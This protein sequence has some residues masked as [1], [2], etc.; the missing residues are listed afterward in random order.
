MNDDD[1]PA[2]ELAVTLAD[3][4]KELRKEKNLLAAEERKLEVAQEEVSFFIQ[5]RFYYFSLF[6]RSDL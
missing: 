5:L 4:D 2:E 6:R 3:M 1:N